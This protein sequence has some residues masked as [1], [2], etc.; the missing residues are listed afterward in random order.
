M[1]TT[2]ARRLTVAVV[3]RQESEVARVGV[4]PARVLHV[5]AVA[6]VGAVFARLAR[7]VHL[8]GTLISQHRVAHVDRGQSERDLLFRQLQPIEQPD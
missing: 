4:A 3:G 7:E 5:V 8:E 2:G 1:S 6:V